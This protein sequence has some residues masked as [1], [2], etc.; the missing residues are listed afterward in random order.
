[1]KQPQYSETVRN[2]RS[3]L[4]PEDLLARVIERG[5][6]LRGRKTKD[7]PPEGTPRYAYVVH[8]KGAPIEAGT[9]G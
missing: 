7:S 8:D 2:N 1:M 5:E 6:R 9:I 3:H 4:T